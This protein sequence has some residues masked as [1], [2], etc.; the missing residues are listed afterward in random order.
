MSEILRILLLKWKKLIIRNNKLRIVRVFHSYFLGR[1]L[2]IFVSA[3]SVCHTEE[4]IIYCTSLSAGVTWK[5][6]DYCETNVFLNTSLHSIRHPCE[7]NGGL[8]LDTKVKD[9]TLKEKLLYAVAF[10]P[11]FSVPVYSDG[12]SSGILK[13]FIFSA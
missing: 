12:F 4:L 13:C 6:V 2:M 11:K 7:T 1:T 5:A 3:C 9:N 10:P 8:L